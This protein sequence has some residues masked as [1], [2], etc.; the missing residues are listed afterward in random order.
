[1]TTDLTAPDAVPLTR[2]VH[3]LP[4]PSPNT[5]GSRWSTSIGLAIALNTHPGCANLSK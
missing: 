2:S 1:M 5:S 4:P 3:D